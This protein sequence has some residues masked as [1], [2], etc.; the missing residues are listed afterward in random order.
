VIVS[1]RGCVRQHILLCTASHSLAVLASRLGLQKSAPYSAFVVIR[2]A[3]AAQNSYILQMG[4]CHL[5]QLDGGSCQAEATHVCAAISSD[6]QML[7][8]RA[9]TG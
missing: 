8:I 7:N 4:V 3:Q 5:V 6:V 9:C 1:A 2:E